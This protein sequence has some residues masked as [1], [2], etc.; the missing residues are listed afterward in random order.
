MIDRLA[1]WRRASLAVL[2]VEYVVRVAWAP[3]SVIAGAV[4]VALLGLVPG[5]VIAPC[6]FLAATL[7]AASF[8]LRTGL[9]G[10]ARPNDAAAEARLERDSALPH[11]PFMVLRDRPAALAGEPGLWSLHLARA[12]AALARL[13]LNAPVPGLP[14]HDPAA[15]RFLSLVVLAAGVTV[16]G[17][18]A[19]PRL[20][21]AFL[22]SFG[23]GAAVNVSL[24]AWVEP[25]AYT[26]LAPILLP[27]DGGA[28][29]VPQGAR[30][31]VSLTGG[32]SKPQLASADGRIKFHT[33]GPGSWQASTILH[34]SG[35][36]KVSLFWREL[37]RW[38][39]DVLPNDPPV[40]NWSG[41]PGKAGESL[42]LSLPWH[43][44]Q[45]WG[46]NGLHASLA[47]IG[48]PD[49]KP[50]E[51]TI[52]LP[53][54]PKDAAGIMRDDLSA[55]P[56]AGVRMDATLIAR[57]LSGQTASSAPAHITLPARVFHNG[58]A[59]AIIELRRRIA[60]GDERPVE[61][62]AD[63][64]AL[65]Q[66]PR[67]AA[68][69]AGQS[70]LYLNLV[71]VGALLRHNDT[72]V[73][74]ADAQA[75]LWIVAL[76][77][78]G[79]LPEPS[80]KALDHARE[81]LKRA[82]AERAQGRKND[83][84]VDRDIR[85]LADALARRY[86]D[87]A[88]KAVREGKMP[89]FDPHQAFHMPSL[90]KLLQEMQQA[91]QRG[92][93]AEAQRKLAEIEKLLNK[94]RDAKVLTPQQAKEA[95]KANK[96][97]RQQTDAVQDMIKREAGLMD[98]AQH[99][100]PRPAPLA[101]QYN[102][103][104]MAP[105]PDTDQLEANEEL[106]GA[107]ARTERALSRALDAVKGAFGATGGK[108]PPAMDDASR[109][110]GAA[111]GALTAGQEGAAR[112]AE[113]RVIADLQKG[114]KSMSDQMAANSQMAIVP[115]A[116][117]PGEEGEEMGQGGGGRE[118]GGERDPLG[119]LVHQGT[120]GKAEDDGSVVVPDTRE[121]ARSRA[122]Q[123]ELRRRGGDRARTREELDYIGRLLK[124]F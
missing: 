39:I 25:P 59:R 79:A 81:A 29:Q 61:A 63:I 1:W 76:A 93:H 66:S 34:Q 47:P 44:A 115:G 17:G 96:A 8:L 6:L 9:R 60:L 20:R 37:G 89:P 5:G 105:P 3:A 73:G 77:L 116:G 53:G 88:K 46:V 26:G 51:V 12:E 49:V 57:D 55:N 32:G 83:S 36:L 102:P 84:E 106:R 67:D 119:R 68:S 85:R 72:P 97:Q 35:T 31:N 52:P 92:D 78:D 27:H 50:V 113:A 107:D 41:V 75:R 87:I 99:R 22:P 64:D 54:T 111:T 43:V 74:V 19:L 82:L 58:L 90:D 118:E 98:N 21:R 95:E 104:G 48:H 11:R 14:G 4:G 28:V 109:D 117:Q 18:D 15:W 110:M 38:S 40:V 122:I 86:A 80:E 120:G 112:Q 100:A 69:L 10:Q 13:R 7:A 62:A 45:R 94:L 65:A 2:W 42:E 91:E 108:V 103:E 123:E 121:E 33:L 114:G 30:L 124:P 24:Q 70:G 56:L 71:S 16:A 101:P 23:T